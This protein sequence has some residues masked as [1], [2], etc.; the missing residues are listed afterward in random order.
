MATR[1]EYL[2]QAR[3]PAETALRRHPFYQGKVPIAPQCPIRSRGD[4]CWWCILHFA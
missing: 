4:F 3:L 2:V 1:E